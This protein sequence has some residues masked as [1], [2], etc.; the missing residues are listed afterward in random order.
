MRKGCVIALFMA[1]AFALSA[2]GNSRGAGSDMGNVVDET[3]STADN[4]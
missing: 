3:V 4:I 2:C 1:A